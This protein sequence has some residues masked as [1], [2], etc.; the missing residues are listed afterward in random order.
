MKKK[1]FVSYSWAD[2][3]TQNDKKEGDVNKITNEILKEIRSNLRAANV[4]IDC[5]IDTEKL[6]NDIFNERIVG[7]ISS[8]DIFFVFLSNNYISGSSTKTEL[9]LIFQREN[10]N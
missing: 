9:S 3:S 1:I 2:N 7:E 6:E 5:F 4:L 10:M 8:S